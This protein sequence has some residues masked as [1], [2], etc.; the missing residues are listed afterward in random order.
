MATKTTEQDAVGFLPGTPVRLSW[1]SIFGG[2]VA[3]LGLWLLL[4]SL[5]LALGLSAMD[6]NDPGSARGAGIFTGVWSLLS[7]LVA[8]FVGGVVASRGSGVMTRGVGALHGLVMW[9]V[10]TLV[11]A[12]LL[13]NLLGSLLGT[14]ASAGSAV[15]GTAGGAVASAA[16]GAANSA[17]GLQGLANAFGLDANDALAPVNE[18]LRAQGKPTV[19][20]EQLQAATKDVVSDA[21]RQGRFDRELLVSSLAQQTALSREDAQE[22][23]GRVEQQ[24]NGALARVQ[25]QAQSAAQGARTG[26]LQAADATGTAFW[27][28]FG[29]LFL[30]LVSALF[31]ATVGVSRRQRVAAE[32]AVVARDAPGLGLRREVH[33]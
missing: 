5:G 16:G 24:F 15:V 13:A 10:T 1:G 27:G 11:G 14:V 30:G 20:P 25:G 22:V 18:R 29:A 2:A 21:V 6:P 28:V 8:L 32:G 31:G 7:P 26:A 23:A 12:Y 9:G 17:G 19:T 3:A 4:Y 33:P